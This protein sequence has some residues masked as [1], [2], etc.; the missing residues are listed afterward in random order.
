MPIIPEHEGM[1][2]TEGYKPPSE[3]SVRD[4]SALDVEDESLQGYNEA[5]LKGT[6]GEETII[7]H[8]L[9]SS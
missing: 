6:G 9:G 7:V 2:E 5:L 8:L 4:I 3:K 1:V